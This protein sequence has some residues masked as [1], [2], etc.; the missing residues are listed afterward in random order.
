MPGPHAS[1]LRDGQRLL[2]QHGPID[3]VVHADGDR[4]E[5]FDAAIERFATILTELV[6][7]LDVLRCPLAK[8]AARPIGDVAR[9]M[10]G[11][12]SCLRF[13]GYVTPMAAV[14]GAVAD[15][16]LGAMRMT[17]ELRRAYVNNGGDIALHLREGET[18]RT[19]IHHHDGQ[20]LGQITIN[21]TDGIGGIATSGRH[22]R[23]MSMGIADSVTTLARSAALADVSA[24][25]IANAVDLPGHPAVTRCAAHEIDD[26]SDLGAERIV[27][28]CARLTPADCGRALS[29]GMMLAERWQHRNL[30]SGTAIFLQGHA[31]VTKGPMFSLQHK[32]RHYA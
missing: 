28:G 11:A 5:A 19:Q 17:A 8:G 6:D 18:F 30:I 9:R 26:Q 32:E 7:E 27:T 10:H 14:A 21:A 16:I 2:L 3:L 1:F 13:A 20:P 15:E 22:G 24:T 23:S 29:N 12:A 31:T 4:K 25:L